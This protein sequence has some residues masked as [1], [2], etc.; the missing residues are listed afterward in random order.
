MI[1]EQ[2]GELAPANEPWRLIRDAISDL[3]LQEKTPGVVIEMGCWHYVGRDQR[4]PKKT[5]CYQCL[6][7]ATISRRCGVDSEDHIA[8]VDMPMDIA[9]KMRALD[10]FREGDVKEAYHCLDIELPDTVPDWIDMPI[11]ERDRTGFKAA[12]LRLADTLEAASKER[13]E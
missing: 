3:E 5:C 10:K 9:Q 7:G 4:Y 1:F 6:A 13:V 2:T 8:A 12:L 11:Y